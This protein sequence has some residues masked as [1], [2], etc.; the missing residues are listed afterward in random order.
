[1]EAL[2]ALF[3]SW[4]LNG[5]IVMA[6]TECFCSPILPDFVLIPLAM[7]KPEI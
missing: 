2:I 4:G 1:M 6:F 5:L 3:L 7:A